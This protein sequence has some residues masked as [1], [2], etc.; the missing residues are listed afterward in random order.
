MQMT[1]TEQVTAVEEFLSG[2]MLGCGL[3]GSEGSLVGNQAAARVGEPEAF[4]AA[5]GANI[6][7]ASEGSA[8]PSPGNDD[9]SQTRFFPA[10]CIPGLA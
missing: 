10:L 7:A 8:P 1:P 6:R 5:V 4:S 3:S 2:T 9:P